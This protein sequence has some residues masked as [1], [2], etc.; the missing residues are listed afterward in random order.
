MGVNFFI[1]SSWSGIDD[2]R[3]GSNKQRCLLDDKYQVSE[4]L[5]LELQANQLVP[6]LFHVFNSTRMHAKIS[7][8]ITI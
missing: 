1:R 2:V 4:E 3:A 8:L 7:L 6:S 5:V